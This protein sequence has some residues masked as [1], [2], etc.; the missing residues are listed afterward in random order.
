MTISG[1]T[2]K[3]IF[4]QS[5]YYSLPLLERNAWLGQWILERIEIFSGL[6]R[7]LERSVGSWSSPFGNYY[8]PL[9]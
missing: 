3:L 2:R 5:W 8:G 4:Y 9:V 6:V 7:D 1:L